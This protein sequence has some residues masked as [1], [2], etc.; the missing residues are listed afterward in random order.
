MLP[1]SQHGNV[2]GVAYAALHHFQA[3][4]AFGPYLRLSK[5]P[6]DLAFARQTSVFGFKLNAAAWERILAAYVGAGLVQAVADSG[7]T[8]VVEYV[9]AL[10][11]LEVGDYSEFE[12]HAGDFMP[13]ETFDHPAQPARPAR[14]A[15]YRGRGARRQLITPAM[16][17]QPAVD[18]RP[19]PPPLRFI[20][21]AHLASL[22]NNGEPQAFWELSYLAGML[23]PCFT[24]ASRDDELSTVRLMGTSLVAAL[25]VRYQVDTDAGA[26]SNLKDLLTTSALSRYFAAHIWTE[27]ELRKEGRDSLLWGGS[28]A[29]QARVETARLSYISIW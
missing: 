7:A 19:G 14:P 15:I 27:D 10:D 11:S 9:D 2:G 26:A 21:M 6:A 16:P 20:S 12:L 8:T 5:N 3:V 13:C 22:E 23:G 28:V 25:R 4:R 24:R 29:D 17:A 1:W 18:A